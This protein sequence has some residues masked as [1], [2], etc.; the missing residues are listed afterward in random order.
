MELKHLRY[1][2]TVAAERSVSRASLQLN[3]SQPSVSRVIHE[4]E[5]EISIPLFYR[6]SSGMTLTSSGEKFFMYANR[7]LS[8]MN[9]AKFEI[10]KIERSNSIINV[11]F[12]SSKYIFEIIEKLKYVGYNVKNLRFF[13]FNSMKQIAA[14][15]DKLLDLA[16]IRYADDFSFPDLECLPFF[17]NEIFAVVPASHRLSGKKSIYLRELKDEKFVVLKRDVHENMNKLLCDACAVSG[18][19]PDITFCANGFMSALATIATGVC[20][21]LLPR[22]IANAAIPGYVYLP[23][24]GGNYCVESA[25]VYRR[26]EKNASV[27]ELAEKIK[28]CYSN[29]ICKQC[30]G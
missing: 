11:G 12:C 29:E 20:V 7:V 5:D 1:F 25:C 18:F 14:V 19:S 10:C 13:E 4:L 17:N 27:I 26:N 22:N 21:G 15:K 30:E 24:N 8:I 9:E 3:V 28:L 16:I 6:T 23:I 2:L